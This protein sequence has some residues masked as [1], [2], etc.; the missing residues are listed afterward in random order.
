M[1]IYDRIGHYVPDPLPRRR[2]EDVGVCYE[3]GSDLD[4][5][6]VTLEGHSFCSRPCMDKSVGRG[7]VSPWLAGMDVR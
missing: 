6:P 2:Q 7:P 4:E 3:C 5:P 1:S